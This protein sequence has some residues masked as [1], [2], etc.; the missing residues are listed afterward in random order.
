M[1]LPIESNRQHR[2]QLAA[3]HQRYWG[4]LLLSVSFFFCAFTGAGAFFAA[5]A[6]NGKS[7]PLEIP[8]FVVSGLVALSSFLSILYNFPR[9]KAA[10]KNLLEELS[11]E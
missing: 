3:I 11:L 2:S 9:W 5:F 1:Y 10:R 4:F 7:S 6:I 8:F